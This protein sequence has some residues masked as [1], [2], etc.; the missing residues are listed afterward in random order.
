VPKSGSHLYGGFAI[1]R[2]RPA[3]REANGVHFLFGLQQNTRLVADIT[4]ELAQA[5]AK[6]TGMVLLMRGPAGKSGR[7]VS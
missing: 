1:F 4:G 3:W 6:R 7:G 5:A 2:M